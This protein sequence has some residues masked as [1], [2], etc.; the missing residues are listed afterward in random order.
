MADIIVMKK[1]L[2]KIGEGEELAIVTITKAEGSTP[3]GVGA[4]MLV[5]NDGKIYGTV[6]GG[7]I[8][9]RIIELSLEAIKKGKSYGVNIALDESGVDMICGGEVDIFIDVYKNKPKLLIIG[10]GH[11]GQA[12]YNMANF[13]DFNIVIFDDREEFANRERFPLAYDLIHGDIKE[14][15]KKYPIDN[16]TYIVIVTRGHNYDEKALEVVVD[17]NAKYIG[18]MGSKKKVITMRKNLMEKGI[19]EESLN[20]LYSPIGIKISSGKPED[21]AFSILSE[22]QL[23]KNKG[24]LVH[25]KDSMRT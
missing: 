5:L 19:S 20:K 10:G 25:M 1:A 7:S 2:E 21:I 24:E 3:R 14:N 13:L 18:A 16:N 9:N 6:G 11:V 17:S 22:I 12:I 4:M 15:L 8:E 23:V